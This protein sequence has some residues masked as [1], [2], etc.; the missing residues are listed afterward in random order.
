MTEN[1]QLI[2]ELSDY[3][4]GIDEILGGGKFE[5]ELEILTNYSA[6]FRKSYDPYTT[7]PEAESE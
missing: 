2:G 5:K 1:L 4:S 6:T 7:I 3:L